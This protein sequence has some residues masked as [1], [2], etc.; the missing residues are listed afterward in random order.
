MPAG[1]GP[2][3]KDGSNEAGKMKLLTCRDLGGPCDAELVAETFE[4]MGN[5]GRQHVVEL[6][7]AGDEDHKIA[8]DRMTEAT[9]EEQKAMMAEL[10]SKFDAA[11]D[12]GV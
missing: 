3:S 1:I 11:P 2:V 6:I 8:A 12:V 9:P 5:M 7:Q 4:E 10:K